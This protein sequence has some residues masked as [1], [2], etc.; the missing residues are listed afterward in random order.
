[1]AGVSNAET[2]QTIDGLSFLPLLKAEVFNSSERPLF[3]H[4][5]NEWGPSGPG[6]GA[7]SAVRLGDWKFI[8]YHLDQRMELFNLKDDI[9]EAHN[10]VAVNPDKTEALAKVL[11][12][13]L[14]QVEAQMPS[15]KDSGKKVPMPIEI[16]K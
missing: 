10:L 16:L 15:I 12:D 1:M 4:Y 7:S 9:G 3:W 6:I 2:V 5:P 14:I 11:S 8:Y 13:Y